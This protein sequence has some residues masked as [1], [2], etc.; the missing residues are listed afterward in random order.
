[1]AI[2]TQRSTNLTRSD[3]FTGASALLLF[4]LATAFATAYVLEGRAKGFGIL[5][6]FLA[7]G[8]SVGLFF[9]GVT[10]N[11]GGKF[12]KSDYQFKNTLEIPAGVTLASAEEE[13]QLRFNDQCRFV[14][15]LEAELLE[16]GAIPTSKRKPKAF[17]TVQFD[18]TYSYSE[19]K[20]QNCP[21]LRGRIRFDVG[22]GEA[23]EREFA[24]SEKKDVGFWSRKGP[25]YMVY[26]ALFDWALEN[27]DE[28]IGLANQER[29]GA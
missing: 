12:F 10:F 18:S 27:V 5:A 6:S 23:L 17:L 19:S 21:D 2:G 9:L 20:K 26:W 4:G 16:G 7:C 1:M 8:G 3:L 11:S 15:C 29:R 25:P 13:H 14:E 22:S 28:L 24:V